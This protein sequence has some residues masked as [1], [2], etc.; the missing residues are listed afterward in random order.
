MA[1][2]ENPYQSPTEANRPRCSRREVVYDTISMV[3]LLFCAFALI[4]FAGRAPLLWLT[5]VLAGVVGALG[6]A[7]LLFVAIIWVKQRLELPEVAPEWN[8]REPSHQD[9]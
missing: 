1:Q 3:W 6:F 4:G 8:A 5:W 7:A 2:F 9:T